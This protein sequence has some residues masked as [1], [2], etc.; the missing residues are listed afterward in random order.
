MSWLGW[1]Y[2]SQPITDRGLNYV[3]PP[4]KGCCR[5]RPIRKPEQAIATYNLG[6]FSPAQLFGIPVLNPEE[7]FRQFNISIPSS[8]Q[9]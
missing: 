1:F 9:L 7:T 3:T 6:D 8:Y 4:M 2:P 5:L